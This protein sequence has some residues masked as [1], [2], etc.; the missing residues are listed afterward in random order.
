M[1]GKKGKEGSERGRGDERKDRERGEYR[2][3]ILEATKQI[4]IDLQIQ[5]PFSLDSLRAQW[6]FQRNPAETL[7][8]SLSL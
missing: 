7:Q 3:N 5:S 2:A 4:F 1:R 6:V 8:Y